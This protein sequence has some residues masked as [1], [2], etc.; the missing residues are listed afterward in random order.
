MN[1]E[2]EEAEGREESTAEVVEAGT[3][4]LLN[5]S[6]IDQQI[7]TAKK[8]PRSIA[9][10]THEA[11]QLVSQNE[12]VADSC[13][14]ALPRKDKSG[15]KKTIKGPSARFAE[16]IT[17]C[18]G[19]NRSGGRVVGE[20]EEFVR[21]QGVFYDLER[22]VAITMEVQRRITDSRGN[23]YGTDMIGVTGNAANSIAQRN[24]VLKGIP[25]AFWEPIY[26]R[27]QEVAIGNVETL[28]NRRATMIAYFMK[29]GVSD[30]QIFETLGVQGLEDIGLDQLGELKGI[31]TA[32]KEGDTTP[33][34]AFAPEA[35]AHAVRADNNLANKSK[36][37]L[38][39][40]KERHSV[41][42]N[43]PAQSEAGSQPASNGEA[44]S[45]APTDSA[46]TSSS[47]LTPEQRQQA[48]EL[49]ARINQQKGTPAESVGVPD[50]FEKPPE[51]AIAARGRKK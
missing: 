4:A 37:R 22:N 12:K 7:A 5:K 50:L 21:S 45:Q 19:N 6:E 31:A 25:K 48:E 49:Q 35:P 1:Y 16:I 24:A 13:I 28:V 39:E 34:E 2:Y 14:Y 36:S 26:D 38:D 9:K 46:S 41:G 30:K 43:Q 51:P 11:T 40:I 15:Q 10:F 32:I 33:E 20:D 17:S 27:A 42:K 3:L 44:A 29:L 8:Y 18:W 23:R 47:T